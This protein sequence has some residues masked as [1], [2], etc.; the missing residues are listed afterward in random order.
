MRIPFTQFNVHIPPVV[1]RHKWKFVI[2]GV[3]FVFFILPAFLLT[4]PKKPEYITAEVTRGNLVQTVEAVGTVT[5][6]KDL[7]LQ[8]RSAGIVSDVSVKQ[9]DIVRAG[10]RLASLRAGSLAA[11]IA[12][13]QASVQ[14]AQAQLQ[15][16]LEGA[17]PEDIA[18]AEASLAN[19][20]A[21][22]YRTHSF[23]WMQAYSMMCR[24]K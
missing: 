1:L 19:K 6:E 16:L 17:R 10:Q 20:K 15:A 2:G 14:E 12:S 5:S 7:D 21:A 9:G 23:V 11:S 22:I 3:V 24:R 8:F 4:R 13:A 18:I